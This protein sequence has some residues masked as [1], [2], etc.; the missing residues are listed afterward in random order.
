LEKYIY[1]IEKLVNAKDV[2]ALLFRLV[3]AYGFYNTAMMKLGN[4]DGVAQWFASMNCPIP[5]LNAY[6]ATFT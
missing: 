6:L 2:Y 3:L 4:I 1:L 5:T